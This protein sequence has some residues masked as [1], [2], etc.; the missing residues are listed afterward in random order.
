[1]IGFLA[2]FLIYIGDKFTRT[3]FYNMDRF[4]M[5]NAYYRSPD[6][7]KDAIKIRFKK[8]VY[9]NMP[10]LII[11]IFGLIGILYQV[12][13]PWFSYLLTIIFSILGM[14]FFNFHY[15]YTYYLIQPF[16]E[17]MEMKNPLYSILNIFAYYIAIMLMV[18][19]EK[20]RWLAIG[21]ILI[22]LFTYI[23]LGF[24]LVTKFSYKRF[25]LR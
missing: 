8:M 18:I 24:I 11:L 4:L 5:K 17:N 14:A 20:F 7:L 6:L 12:K 25:K 10:M 19:V 13:T 21:G 3:C 15:L 16:T 23:I 2:G 9:F 1:L 22:F